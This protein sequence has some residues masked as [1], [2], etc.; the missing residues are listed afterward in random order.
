MDLRALRE[1]QSVDTRI[2]QARSASAR[3]SERTAHANAV[4][5]LAHVRATRDEICRSQS[6]MESELVD[7]EVKSADIDTH[8]GRLEKQMKT[9][10]APREA[11]ALQ[12]ELASL[13][14]QRN[15]LDDRGLTLLES[16]SEADAKLAEL[17]VV[18]ENAVAAEGR[19]GEALAAAESQINGQLSSLS[20]ERARLVSA[21]SPSEIAEYERRRKAQ[22]G[23]AVT[24]IEH[25]HCNGC[26]M[27]LSVSELDAIKRLPADV[28]AECPNCSRLLA[29]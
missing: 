27:D 28:D 16:S 10:I 12:H 11:E 25:G 15:E 18:E 26:H 19:A 4:S 17:V 7:I 14:A 9:V 29:R 23:V 5:D 20:D 21:I 8:R 2:D 22:A 1:L 13:A 6:A 3:L 24:E